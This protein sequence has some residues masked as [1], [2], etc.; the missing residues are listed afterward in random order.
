MLRRAG[1]LPCNAPRPLQRAACRLLCALL[2]AQAPAPAHAAPRRQDGTLARFFHV[3]ELGALA[4]D[5]GAE[6]LEVCARPHA[7]R[8]LAP[9]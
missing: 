8:H 9:H 6:Q 7:L 4:R 3:E 2:H 5:A 1:A